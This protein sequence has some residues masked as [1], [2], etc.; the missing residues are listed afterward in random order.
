MNIIIVSKLGVHNEVDYKTL[1]SQTKDLSLLLVEDYEPLREDM[2]EI[3][4][5]FFHTVSVAVNGHEAL[6][7]YQDHYAKENK[8]F[9]LVLTDIQMPIMDGVAL[10]EAIRAISPT[11][12]I[13]VLSAHTDTEYLLKLINLG[14]AQFITKPIDNENLMNTLFSV[15]HTVNNCEIKV[16]H[17]SLVDLG[18]G[19]VWDKNELTLKNSDRYVE[20]TR[21][22]LLLLQLMIKKSNQVC[23]TDD[24]MNNFYANN[25]DISDRNIRNMVF[26]LRKKLPEAAISSIYGLGYTLIP[27]V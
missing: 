4:E 20:L 23:T 3:L 10:C 12:E 7:V 5:D 1:Y 11:Q 25:I 24:I 6:K 16:E 9:D 17:T 13:I 22:E 21:N 14:I 18:E 2:A 8:Y 15:S 26:K 27:T 19:Y